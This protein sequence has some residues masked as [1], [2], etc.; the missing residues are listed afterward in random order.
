MP[1][2]L[3]IGLPAAV[4]AMVPDMCPLTHLFKP[5]Q[6]FTKFKPFS[7]QFCLFSQYLLGA[8][9]DVVLNELLGHAHLFFP[10]L[11]FCEG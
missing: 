11:N 3:L 9:S 1:A 7:S 5:F 8:F 10:P 2:V 4:V 6:F